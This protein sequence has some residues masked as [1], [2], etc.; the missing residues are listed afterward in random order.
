MIYPCGCEFETIDYENIFHSKAYQFGQ[1]PAVWNMLSVGHTKGIFQLESQLGQNW[2]KH[3]KP[4]ELSHLAGLIAIL[5]PGVLNAKTDDGISMA[6]HYVR[7]KN[8]IEPIE[9]LHPSLEPILK[10]T[11]G[12]IIYQ[13]QITKISQ[14]LCGMTE[15]EADI[16]RKGIGKKLPEV[17]AKC[18]SIF[19]D[20]AKKQ[21]II[22]DDVAN[23]LWDNIEKSNRYLF[24]KSHSYEYATNLLWSA[25]AKAHDLQKFYDSYL[26]YANEKQ[27]PKEEIAELINDAKLADISVIIP[28]IRYSKQHFSIYQDAIIFG[29]C[30][31]KGIGNAQYKKIKELEKPKSWMDCLLLYLKCLTEPTARALIGAGALDYLGIPRTK[32]I[33]E[34]DKFSQINDKE[35]EWGMQYADRTTL[36]NFI[37]DIAPR[38]KTSKEIEGSRK[39]GGTSTDKRSE[40]LGGLVN[41]LQNP[42][43]KLEDNIEWIALIEQQLLGISITCFKVDSCDVSSANCTCKE[44]VSGRSGPV[45]LAVEI[46]KVKEYTTKDKRQ[47]A[48]L[49]VSDGTCNLD[50]VVFSDAFVTYSNLLQPQNTVLLQG[51]RDRK[52]GGFIVKK[53]VQI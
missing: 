19:I 49:G 18:K 21:S 9:Y 2:V 51:E 30:D 35:L 17:V 3:L 50:A 22:P 53:V 38:K 23:T 28:D 12:I 1:C 4:T 40:L 46:N 7:R 36:I 52:R 15:E 14:I 41:S 20:G 29:L 47:M 6:D 42:P 43:Y 37:S 31:I 10:E 27:N 24:N 8:G 44:F 33:Y 16:L 34:Y 26:F 5:R 25:Y 45:I 39:F 13:E 48:F 11:F 32:M